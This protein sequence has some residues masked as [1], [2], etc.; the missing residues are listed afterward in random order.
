[1]SNTKRNNNNKRGN[2][3]GGNRGGNKSSKNPFAKDPVQKE[4]DKI[5]VETNAI[6]DQFAAKLDQ[7]R[8]LQNS[9]Y[10]ETMKKSRAYLKKNVYPFIEEINAEEAKIRAT[11]AKQK[12]EKK[13]FFEDMKEVLP[14]RQKKGQPFQ[15][16]IQCNLDAVDDEIKD[17]QDQLR[18][19]RSLQDE[20][21]ITSS[22]D[23]VKSRKRQI[24]SFEEKTFESKNFGEQL[25]AL[26][27]KKQTYFDDL[28]KHK[29][30][31]AENQK[32]HDENFTKIQA[33]KTDLDNLNAKRDELNKQYA[34][35]KKILDGK[36]AVWKKEQ[37]EIKK[38]KQAEYKERKEREAK[39]RQEE[40]ERR[41]QEEAKRPPMMKELNAVEGLITYLDSLK[42]NKKKLNVKI[43]H[44]LESFGKFSEFKLTPPQRGKN[45]A[46]CRE[47]L[48]AKK[49]EIIALQ[50]EALKK[51]EEE[52]AAQQKLEEEKP[53]TTEEAPKEETPAAEAAK[54]EPEPVA[55][56][57]K[58]ETAK[59]EVV[60]EEPVKEEAATEEPA[61]DAPAA[62]ED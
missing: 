53:A 47:A 50:T 35:K 39:E 28:N 46:A 1:M 52:A 37:E 5:K 24:A 9:E 27:A 30:I 3:K 22:I 14:V 6:N 33:L 44:S 49:E 2:N 17:L 23:K 19:V 8:A 26:K 16:Y 25:D 29:A 20:K 18:N 10:V 42:I 38:K 15:D 48:I 54:E 43:N 51:R 56:E 55:E 58:E 36:W 4:A 40:E 32:L 61:E 34:E 41:K 62:A 31:I 59:E 57:V 13:R 11:M 21:Q 45:V 12:E 60:A 7:I